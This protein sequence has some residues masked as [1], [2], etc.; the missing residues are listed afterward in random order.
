MTEEVTS[1]TLEQLVPR[2]HVHV[3]VRNL[4][5]TIV[6]AVAGDTVELSESAELIWRALAPGRTVRE[7]ARIVAE[8]YD[9]PEEAV[10]PDVIDWL[11]DLHDRGFVALSASGGPARADDPPATAET[12]LP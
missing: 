12:A 9:E 6:V 11:R 5:G 3:R 8:R 2:P 1:S 10:L 4:S 7:V